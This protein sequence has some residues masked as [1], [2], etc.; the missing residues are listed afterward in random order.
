MKN[1]PTAGSFYGAYDMAGNVW[2]WVNDWYMNFI[3]VTQMMGL[4][5]WSS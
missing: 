2:E 1:Y 4:G 5:F 3:L